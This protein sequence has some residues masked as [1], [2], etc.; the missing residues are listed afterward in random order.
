TVDLQSE[1]GRATAERRGRAGRQDA[2]QLGQRTRRVLQRAVLVG[3][4]DLDAAVGEFERR[5]RYPGNGAVTAVVDR[6]I[7]ADHL[8]G[9]IAQARRLIRGL[10]DSDDRVDRVRARRSL[11]DCSVDVEVELQGRGGTLRVDTGKVRCVGDAGHLPRAAVD[12]RETW[13]QLVHRGQRSQQ[14]GEVEAQRTD[15]LLEAVAQ[16]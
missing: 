11:L 7:A 4:V 2:D 10:H 16:E 6:L 14:P 12:H 3:G 8:D 15:P 9:A 5:R 13:Q 1:T